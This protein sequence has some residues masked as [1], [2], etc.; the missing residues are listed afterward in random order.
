MR[1]FLKLLLPHRFRILMAVIYSSLAAFFTAAT[2]LLMQPLMD[3]LFLQRSTT[4]AQG[5]KVSEILSRFV[6]LKNPI[7]IPLL[8]LGVF[9]G[10]SLFTFLSNYTMRSLAYRISSKLRERLFSSVIEAPMSFFSGVHTGQINSRFIY[11]MSFIER[12]VSEGIVQFVREGLTLISLVAVLFCNNFRLAL[13]AFVVIPLAAIPV[14]IFGR[15]IKQLTAKTQLA[16]GRLLKSLQEALGGIKIVK[17]FSMERYEKEKFNRTNRVYLKEMLRFTRL[18]TFTSPFMEFLGGIAGAILIY[19]GAIM[20]KKGTMTPG[21]FTSFLAALFYIYTP[22]KRL[23]NANNQ[24]QQGIAA[25]ESID[26]LLKVP[27]E[28]QTRKG[29]YRPERIRGEVEFRDVYFSYNGT[30]MILKGVSFKV[31]PGQIVALVGH[32]GAGKTT[33]VNLILGFY[34]P[35]RGQ[36]LIDGVDLREYDLQHLRRFIGIVTQDVFIFNDTIRNNIAY[37]MK[38]ITDEDIRRAAQI[39]YIHDFIESLPEGYET[40]LGEKGENLSLGQ[41]QRISIARAILKDP[42][43]LILDEATSSLDAESEYYVQ[44][45]L[46]YLLRGRTTFVIAHRLSTVKMAHRILVIENGTVAEEGTHEELLKKGGLYS[47]LYRT[48]LGG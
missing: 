40:M 25:V 6:D 43:I 7:V 10:K 18:T 19:M 45:A 12:A 9:F 23:S 41:R 24:I 2:A 27:S 46:S 38:D 1:K 15:L 28:F 14:V 44:K 31:E 47:K 34:E 17:A 21:Q 37:G 36:I 42:P 5:F 3:E 30:D 48:Q 13:L 20:I 11:E 16:M 8:V 32:S 33:I 29:R 4:G 39:A 35:T 26:R 22:I